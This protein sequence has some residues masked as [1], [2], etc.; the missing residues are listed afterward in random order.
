MKIIIICLTISF[1]FFTGCENNLD[2]NNST[3]IKGTYSGYYIF[4]SDNVTDTGTVEIIFEDTSYQCKPI[5]AGN[6]LPGSGI[7]EVKSNKLNITDLLARVAILDLRLVMNGEFSYSFQYNKLILFQKDLRTNITKK[8][9]L[10]KI[11]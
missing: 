10:V 4:K 8:F 1:L 7:Y 3:S 11:K 5:Q 6:I 2:G 9:E